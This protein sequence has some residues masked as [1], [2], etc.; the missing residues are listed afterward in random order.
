M[1]QTQMEL[2]METI[3][4]ILSFLEKGMPAL[5]LDVPR[6]FLTIRNHNFFKIPEE[7]AI[8][9]KIISICNERIEFIGEDERILLLERGKGQNFSIAKRAEMQVISEKE[10]IVLYQKEETF[11]LRSALHSVRDSREISDFLEILLG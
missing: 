6:D 11:L 5:L 2:S 7:A 3:P 8:P 1:I 9:V 4:L 10:T